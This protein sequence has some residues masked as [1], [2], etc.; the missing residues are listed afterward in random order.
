MKKSRRSGAI[1]AIQLTA[2]LSFGLAVLLPAVRGALTEAY[3][4][5]VPPVPLHW[6]VT[7]PFVAF[8]F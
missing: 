3:T 4:L 5:F 7:Q 2:A 8:G 6:T 1:Q